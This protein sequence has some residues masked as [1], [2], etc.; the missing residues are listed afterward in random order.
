MKIKIEITK[1]NSNSRKKETDIKP[2]ELEK[3]KKNVVLEHIKHWSFKKKLI[4]GGIATAL[5]IKAN[6]GKEIKQSEIK[7]PEV[8][9]SN[10]FTEIQTEVIRNNPIK[11]NA[12]YLINSYAEAETYEQEKALDELYK[13]KYLEVTGTVGSLTENRVVLESGS[14]DKWYGDWMGVKCDIED[15]QELTE[16]DNLQ[17]GEEVTVM[18]YC[19]GLDAMSIRLYNCD[20][21]DVQEITP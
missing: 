12:D 13:Y 5:I 17:V 8:E 4:V 15:Q 16:L 14:I 19:Q 18:G 2:E 10:N 21:I 1:S 3:Q 7:Q 20:I 11:I 9:Q 6:D